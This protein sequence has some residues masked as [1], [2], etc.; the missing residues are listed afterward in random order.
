MENIEK[1]SNIFTQNN[2]SN[3]SKVG[4]LI[5]DEIKIN[6]GLVW[7]AESNELIGFTDLNFSSCTDEVVATNILQ[8]FF[9][10]FIF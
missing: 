10:A 6:E 8:F 4:A 5:F 3:Q 2:Y 1:M 9:Q 7:T